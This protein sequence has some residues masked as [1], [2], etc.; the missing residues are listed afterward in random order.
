MIGFGH[1][2]VSS[3]NPQTFARPP[4]QHLLPPAQCARPPNHPVN[5][6]PQPHFVVPTCAAMEP[7]IP[8]TYTR[9]FRPVTYQ[10]FVMPVQ[11]PPPNR[12]PPPMQQQ[13]QSYPP[14]S[15]QFVPPSSV[16]PPASYQ[17]Q[18]YPKASAYAKSQPQY[19]NTSNQQYPN[20]SNQ[21]YPNTSSQ[22]YPNTSNQQ[23]PNT[24]NQQY[25]NTSNQQYHNTSAY[26]EPDRT[27]GQTVANWAGWQGEGWEITEL[28]RSL[29]RE[30]G[31]LL[32]VHG[33]LGERDQPVLGLFMGMPTEARQLIK[34]CGGV[35]AFLLQSRMFHEDGGKI[36]LL[37]NPPPPPM[38]VV[39]STDSGQGSWEGNRVSSRP[40]SG[41]NPNA[42]EFVPS[43][44]SFSEAS[45][46]DVF[47]EGSEETGKMNFQE[48]YKIC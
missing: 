30:F 26:A 37:D 12:Y 8:L 4:T 14:Q 1:R 19:P 7:R 33:P 41:I 25:P 31:T 5:Y 38:Q 36:F 27:N 2:Q 28:R 22:Q 20:T 46:D 44:C 17:P 18:Q 43:E 32:T 11:H 6:L 15:G 24:S 21:Q 29:Y 9:P 40:A 34:E 47:V 16:P 3:G 10:P 39:S 48:K 13:Q 23:Y 35:K 45:S 42:V